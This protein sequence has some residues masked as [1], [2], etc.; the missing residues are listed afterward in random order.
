MLVTPTYDVLS[1]GT[2]GLDY[3]LRVPYW[4][5]PERGAHT[6]GEEEHLGGKAA[7]TAA[8][9][10]AWGLRVALSGSMLGDDA[11][12]D[13]V[14]AHL[15]G[16]PGLS[17]HYLDRAAGRHS[18][19]CRILVNPAGERTII[20]VGVD[21]VITTPPTA[22][23]IADARVLT[24]DLFGGPERVEAARLAAGM[25]HPVVVGDVNRADHPV[26]P[27]ASVA[28]VSA[29]EVGGHG[30]PAEAFARSALAAGAGAVIVTDG[31]RDVAIYEPGC[32]PAFVSP[33]EVP[34]VDTTGAGDAFRA[35]VVYGL[36]KGWPLLRAAAMGAAAGSLKVGVAG[37]ATRVP[38]LAEVLGLAEGLPLR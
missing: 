21:E 27:F 36:V 14:V 2:I 6:P 26:L 1:Y 10:A 33:P 16:F 4:P 31:P 9:L 11:V 7:N 28:L 3:I 17:T 30:D 25:G 32:E 8:F 34:V 22:E 29:D 18:M 37:A 19:Y 20:G 15:G 35:G 5:T 13:R 23:M 24:L 38:P 12:G